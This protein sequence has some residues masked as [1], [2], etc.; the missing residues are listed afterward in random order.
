MSIKLYSELIYSPHPSTWLLL[1]FFPTITNLERYPWY[2]SRL[3]RLTEVDGPDKEADDSIFV[4]L[5]VVFIL[6]ISRNR[7]LKIYEILLEM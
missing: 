1:V 6:H 3:A 5:P 4:A 7:D 2:V